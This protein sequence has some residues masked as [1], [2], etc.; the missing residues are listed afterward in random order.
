MKFRTVGASRQ[1]LNSTS[2]SCE[3][4][5][6]H[7]EVDQHYDASIKRRFVVDIPPEGEFEIEITVARCRMTL[8]DG[9]DWQGDAI[10]QPD[11]GLT[12]RVV[13]TE[14]GLG[15]LAMPILAPVYGWMYDAFRKEG[16]L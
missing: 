8:P 7:Y 11:R 9:F 15:V 12:W 14:A 2:E 5:S 1:L 16:L 3:G 10:V 13:E 4:V 6:V